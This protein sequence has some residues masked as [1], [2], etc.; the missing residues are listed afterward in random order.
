MRVSMNKKS[1]ADYISGNPELNFKK[2]V[3]FYGISLLLSLVIVIITVTFFIVVIYLEGSTG[4]VLFFMFLGI[5]MTN[6][7]ISGVSLMK[8]MKLLTNPLMGMQHQRV[9]YVNG[10][11]KRRETESNNL[12]DKLTSEYFTEIELQ[13]VNLLKSRGNRML[14]SDIVFDTGN[15]KASIS[16]TLT[17][18]ERKGVV[19][20]VRKGVTNEIILS[21]T[22]SK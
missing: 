12:S 1:K 17:S 15:S 3:L 6:L 4:W 11:E 18:L 14:Q 20:R 8:L 5:I 7:A 16:R 21:E 2:S 10:Q 19:I 13:L 9:Y 22:Y